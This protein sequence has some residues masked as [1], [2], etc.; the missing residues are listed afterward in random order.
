MLSRSRGSLGAAS[1]RRGSQEQIDEEWR[2]LRKSMDYSSPS[3][4][5]ESEPANLPKETDQEHNG[6][7]PPQK[8][9]KSEYEDHGTEQRHRSH[10]S[11]KIHAHNLQKQVPLSPTNAEIH[12]DEDAEIGGEFFLGKAKVLTEEFRRE[13][14]TQ[15]TGSDYPLKSNTQSHEPEDVDHRSTH[16]PR[17]DGR[18][19]VAGSPT[20]PEATLSFWGLLE[21]LFLWCYQEIIQL[22]GIFA[23]FLKRVLP[24]LEE[25]L[26]SADVP[27]LTEE[28]SQSR[29]IKE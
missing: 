27:D 8:D 23:E 19:T 11:H 25:E 13:A 7:L 26:P 12:W 22:L 29:S 16:D 15:D 21:I 14:I 28:I 6:G 18:P 9:T 20:H 24:P 3:S 5:E 2:L 1:V 10:H 17:V 4:H